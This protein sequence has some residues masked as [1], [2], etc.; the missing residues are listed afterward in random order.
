MLFLIDRYST[1]RCC[2]SSMGRLVARQLMVYCIYV[3]RRSSASTP[4]WVSTRSVSRKTAVLRVLSDILLAIDR[5]DLAALILLDLTAAFDTADH[6][7]LLQRLH[8]SYGIKDVAL[9]WFQSYLLGRSQYIRRGSTVVALMR[10]V[11]PQESAL[12]PIYGSSC[13]LHSAVG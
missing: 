4:I 2:S 8:L 7:I 10:G 6:D 11:H 9:Q 13:T 5:G 3:V 1:Y 12:G